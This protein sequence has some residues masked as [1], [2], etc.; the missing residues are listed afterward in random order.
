M[1]DSKVVVKVQLD[2]MPM[3]RQLRE[4]ADELQRRY[5]PLETV[6]AAPKTGTGGIMPC[7]GRQALEVPRTD[8]MTLYPD[9]V[10][11]V[12]PPVVGDTR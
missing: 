11:C 8:R 10:T 12:N 6:H 5:G 4:M 3:V 9:E 7:C 1:A 2:V